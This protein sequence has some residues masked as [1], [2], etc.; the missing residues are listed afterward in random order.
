MF[1]N[2][3]E[4]GATIVS[5]DFNERI[6]LYDKQKNTSISTELDSFVLIDVESLSLDDS[7]MEYTA[8]TNTEKTLKDLITKAIENREKNFYKSIYDP[9]VIVTQTGNKPIL[10]LS[11]VPNAYP[12][13]YRSTYRI[14]FGLDA[15]DWANKCYEMA[16]EYMPKYNSRIGTSLQYAAFVGFLVKQLSKDVG[17]SSAWYYVCRNSKNLGRYNRLKKSVTGKNP[18]CGFYDLANTKKLLDVKYCGD[19]YSQ[20]YTLASGDYDSSPTLYPIASIKQGSPFLM[21]EWPTLTFLSRFH[22]PEPT[23]NEFYFVPWVVLSKP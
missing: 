16:Q 19:L 8:V 2:N 1:N 14:N 11:F 21:S 10:R 22:F 13:T 4:N 15:C 12:A 6:R 20:K 3:Y 23:N 18:V 17:V 7:F 5:S 9:S